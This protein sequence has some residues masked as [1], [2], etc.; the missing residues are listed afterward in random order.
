M[1]TLVSMA[2]IACVLL[3]GVASAEEYEAG[4]AA[5]YYKDATNWNGLWPDDTDT[6]M[7]D[8][9]TATFTEFKYTRVEPVVNHL[10]V[11]SGWF[12][13]RW[14]GYIDVPGD[15]E[16]VFVF[17]LWAD[18][19]CR[20]QID[21]EVLIN[22]WYACPEDIEASHRLATK[23]LSPGKHRIVVEYFQGQSLEENDADPVK[24]YWYCT[25]IGLSR[26]VVPAEKLSHKA[27]DTQNPDSWEIKPPATVDPLAE[28]LWEDGQ[29]AE[30]AGDYAHALRLYRRILVIAPD[31]EWA[32]KARARIIEIESDPKIEK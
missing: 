20:L 18:D 15:G 13:V 12:S 14:V 25:A 28:G 29:A 21:D 27:E 19:G 26:E 24:L 32:T 2:A 3:V 1:R 8:P 31:T 30:E 9:K 10:F 11:R 23:K 7:T 5:H 6:P 22:S 16:N 17:E 4:L